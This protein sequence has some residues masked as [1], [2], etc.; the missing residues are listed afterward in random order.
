MNAV[1]P[2]LHFER[3]PATYRTSALPLPQR[4]NVAPRFDKAAIMRR[5]WSGYRTYLAR[6]PAFLRSKS[7]DRRFWA[8]HLKMAWMFAKVEVEK[9]ERLAATRAEPVSYT[10]PK[11]LT[12]R[13]AEIA[14]ELLAIEYSD[15]WAIPT[16]DRIR[17][18]R[19]EL[20]ELEA[21]RGTI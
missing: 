1:S 9:A 14:A 21:D 16:G 5:A 19:A 20:A 11:P 3:S 6:T 2:S 8:Y 17:N 18:L 13:A 4:T 10:A 15:A 7:E 12:G